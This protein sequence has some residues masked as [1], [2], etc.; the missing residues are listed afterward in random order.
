MMKTALPCR[1]LLPFNATVWRMTI[2][3]ALP[4]AQPLALDTTV[5]RSTILLSQTEAYYGHHGLSRRRPH[6]G[7]KEVCPTTCSGRFTCNSDPDNPCHCRPDDYC[8]DVNLF[9]DDYTCA[10][11][12]IGT[13]NNHRCS[14]VAI[15]YCNDCYAK[16]GGHPFTCVAPSYHCQC[17]NP[18]T[19]QSDVSGPV[20]LSNDCGGTR[21]CVDSKC[22]CE[23]H[24]ESVDDCRNMPCEYGTHE[25]DHEHK[26]TCKDPCHNCA[27]ECRDKYTCIEGHRH[28]VTC[29]CHNS[30]YCDHSVHC[31]DKCPHGGSNI[32]LGN[33]CVCRCSRDSECNRCPDTGVCYQNECRCIVSTTTI[34]TTTT[35]TTTPEPT[36]TS[37]T[38]T[39]ATT[40]ATTTT[41]AATTTAATSTVVTDST[42][43]CTTSDDCVSNFTVK[44]DPFE[45]VLCEDPIWRTCTSGYCVC[46]KSLTRPPPTP[47]T[48]DVDVTAPATGGVNCPTCDSLGT[49]TWERCD[50]ADVCMLR[51]PQGKLTAHCSVKA[52]CILIQGMLAPENVL[53]C[54]DANCVNQILG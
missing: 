33:Q 28:H 35:T 50:A 27:T 44:W 6:H 7:C 40:I 37:T 19:C 12:Q 5:F 43:A 29:T 23:F 45:F 15:D 46:D 9:C 49:C 48:T 3:T 21:K 36:T 31:V 22:Q 39:T 32:C 11:N 10:S 16:C 20:C 38:P 54:D 30:T 1:Q 17:H 8:D 51:S 41:T 26:C 25:C 13:C 47:D 42:I 53:C 18:Q 14:C 24:C 52:D 34:T 4:W 2:K